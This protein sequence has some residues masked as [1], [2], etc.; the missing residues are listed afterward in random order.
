MP[1]EYCTV[2]SCR[3][4]RKMTKRNDKYGRL[5]TVKY[6]AMYDTAGHCKGNEKI[7]F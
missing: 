7:S 6:V 5:L 3:R 4:D 2:A 1:M